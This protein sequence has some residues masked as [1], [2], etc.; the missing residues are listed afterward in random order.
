MGTSIDGPIFVKDFDIEENLQLRQLNELLLRVGDDQKAIIEE[1]IKLINI[2]LIG[3]KNTHFEIMHSYIPLLCLH[4]IRLEYNGLSAQFD[5][6]IICHGFIMVL[7]T[8]SLVGDIIIDSD[9][10]FTRVYKDYRGSIYKKEGMYSPISQ[11]QKHVDL[12]QRFLSDNK[13]NKKLPIY[14]L[15]IVANP[16][17]L[18]D[19]KYATRDVKNMII[20]YDQIK[21]ELTERLRQ[22]AN[23]TVSDKA[24]HEIA[25]FILENHKPIKYDFVTRFNLKLKPVE[26]ESIIH[27]EIITTSEEVDPDINDEL[28]EKLRTYRYRKAKEKNLDK[29]YFV[30][31][32]QVLTDIILKLPKTKEELLSIPGFGEKKYQEYGQDILQIINEYLGESKQNDD[33]EENK[34]SEAEEPNILYESLRNY[35][36]KKSKEENIKPY[37]IFNNNELDLLCSLKPITI[38]ELLKV[39]GFGQ[40]KVSKYGEDIISIIKNKK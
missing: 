21:K 35:R 38:D 16:K 33:G 12:L 37:M 24:M 7:E 17:T 39:P 20:K 23:N 4:D 32:N 5:F 36:F 29:L 2:G 3:E 19:K 40:F 9:G 14:S 18:I 13:V 1:Q 15:V 34:K 6:I 28:Y 11:N 26:K 31:N 10:N 8:K 25:D 22:N 30:Y 27:E